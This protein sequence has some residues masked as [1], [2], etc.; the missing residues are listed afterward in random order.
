MIGALTD[1]NPNHSYWLVAE[2][3]HRKTYRFYIHN[4]DNRAADGV[5]LR[6][7]FG[8][9]HF[10]DDILQTMNAPCSM[11]EMMIALARRAEFQAWGTELPQSVG[12]WFWL[13]MR[14]IGLDQFSDAVM[15]DS[16]HCHDEVDLILDR[17]IERRYDS[18]GRGG[19]FPLRYSVEDQH[20]VEVWYQLSAYILE[21]T[22]LID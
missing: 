8:E 13:M 9:H 5:A 10:I 12:D 20:K 18:R 7:E 22:D 1:R 17:V 21:N 6:E 11:L 14:N 2:M 4:D 3:M 19:L 15:M 16:P